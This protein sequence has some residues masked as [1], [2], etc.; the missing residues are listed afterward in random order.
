MARRGERQQG[1]GSERHVSSN[2]YLSLPLRQDVQA[3]NSSPFGATL[4]VRRR[5]KKKN[6]LILQ[7]RFRSYVKEVEILNSSLP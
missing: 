3:T 6:E 2:E 7:R 1:S 5:K 4:Y